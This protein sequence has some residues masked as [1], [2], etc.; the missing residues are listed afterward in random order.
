MTAC[1]TWPLWVGL[2]LI[3]ALPASALGLSELREIVVGAEPT[4]SVS[5]AAEDL[6]YHL[7]RITGAEI[8]AV[9]APTATPAVF[10]GPQAAGLAGVDIAELGLAA[11]ECVLRTVPAGLV[12][13]GDESYASDRGLRSSGTCH[14]VSL[15][16]ERCCGVTWLWPGPTG[17]VIPPDPELSVPDLDLRARPG[18]AKRHIDCYYQR[19]WRQSQRDALQTWMTRTRQG[20]TIRGWFGHSWATYI[21]ADQYFAEHPEWFAE[22]EGVRKPPQLCTS[23]PELRAEFLRRMLELPLNRNMDIWSVSANDGLGFCRCERCRAQGS[24]GDAYWDFACWVAEQI[25][26]QAPGRGIGSFAYGPY[27]QPPAGVPVLPENFYLSMTTYATTLNS[28][29]DREEYTRF[30]QAWQS[31]RPR[32]IMREYWGMH[33]WLD[34]PVVYTDKIAYELKLGHEAGLIGAYGE[35]GKNFSTQAP[36]Y[37]LIAQLTWDPT[38]SAEEVLDRFYTR[39]FGP[40]ADEVRAYFTGFEAALE[41][42]WVELELSVAYNTLIRSWHRVFTPEVLDEAEGHLAA[43]ERLAAGDPAV[44]SRLD[45]LRTGLEYTRVMVALAE[46]Y[47]RLAEAGVELEHFSAQV[48]VAELAPEQLRAL[49]ERAWELGQRRIELLN[50][51]VENA[52][53]DEGLYAHTIRAKLR[54]WHQTVAAQLGKPADAIVPLDYVGAEEFGAR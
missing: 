5:W 27:R 2:V 9:E 6:R 18:F 35:A 48:E 30:L 41:R 40:A 25:Q 33:Y 10:V 13:A 28:P 54:Q 22:V 17:E 47:L 23:N 12:L 4:P 3:A 36:N 42:G 50:A 51:N 34:L 38:Q 14:A 32:I 44:R 15:F 53:L 52:A 26:H 31:R 43:A 29:A 39:G 19:F 24:E 45:F 46:V 8:P 7:Q 21:P 49:L 16:L 11:E 37:Y 1:S 20:N